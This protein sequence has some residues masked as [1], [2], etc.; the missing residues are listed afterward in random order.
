MAGLDLAGPGN[1][2]I[3]GRRP[4]QLPWSPAQGRAGP[5][6][7]YCAAARIGT[8]ALRKERTRLIGAGQQFRRGAPRKHRDLGVR[9][10]RGDV[11]RGLQ[12]VRRGVVRQHQHRGAAVL[13]EIARHAVQEVGLHTVEVVQVLFDLRHGQIGP[14]RQQFGGPDI[15]AGCIHVRPELRPVPDALAEYRGGDA[16]GRAF[17][18]LAGKAA[19]DAVAHIEELADAEMVHQPELVV[20]KGVPRV[21]GRDRAGGFAAIGVALVHRDNAEVVFQ[22]LGR[23]EHGGRP[24]ADPRVQAAAGGDQQWE[25]GTGLLVADADVAFLIKRHGSFPLQCLVRGDVPDP[26]ASSPAACKSGGFRTGA[27]ISAQIADR[28]NPVAALIL[29]GSPGRSLDRDLFGD[30]RWMHI[31]TTRQLKK[32][33]TSTA[34]LPR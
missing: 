17:E 12:R 2:C 9:R 27:D 32:S 34:Q 15:L 24:V 18:Q 25:A 14:P 30:R 26:P 20:G 33:T 23:V 31:R 28:L 16:P 3:P 11:D 19:A 1:P 21:A 6:Q 5:R 22:G 7:G 8:C 13:D 4:R 10:Q 29:P